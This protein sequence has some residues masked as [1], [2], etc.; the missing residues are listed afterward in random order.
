MFVVN[1]LNWMTSNTVLSKTKGKKKQKDTAI[2]SVPLNPGEVK[3]C[4]AQVK[5]DVP[6]VF[7]LYHNAVYNVDK[8][9]Y[10]FQ[11][12]TYSC[13]NSFVNNT[14]SIWLSMYFCIFVSLL[15]L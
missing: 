2:L 14:Q 6:I 4:R 8:V 3:H 15:N 9:R 7:H 5:K 1:I 10:N 11:W 13:N 12:K